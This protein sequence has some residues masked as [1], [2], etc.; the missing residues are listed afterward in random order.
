MIFTRNKVMGWSRQKPPLWLS[1]LAVAFSVASSMLGVAAL[2]LVHQ[3][4]S[5]FHAELQQT[6]VGSGNPDRMASWE[7][8]MRSEQLAWLGILALIVLNAGLNI[9][10]AA[11]MLRQ[12]RT[13]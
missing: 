5:G 1:R 9:G 3:A 13:T 8:A 12:R 2:L 11:V 10:G 6:L 7:E 4:M